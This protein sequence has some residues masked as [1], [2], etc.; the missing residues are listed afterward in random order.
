MHNRN[1]F[2]KRLRE[3]KQYREAMGRCRT[4]E[5]RKTVANLVET[6]VGTVGDILGPAIERAQKDPEFSRRL[7][8]ALSEHKR[9]L[10]NSQMNVSGSNA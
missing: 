10:S 7:A 5:E 6:F 4:S 3:D 1:D 8:R 2:I 9:V